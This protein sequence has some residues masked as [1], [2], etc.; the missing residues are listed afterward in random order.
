[1]RDLEE[2][3]ES[4]DLQECLALKEVL[5]NQE[6]LVNFLHQEHCHQGKSSLEVHQAGMKLQM[7]ES[8]Q[9]DLMTEL[10][11]VFHVEAFLLKAVLVGTAFDEVDIGH[12]QQASLFINR[13]MVKKLVFISNLQNIQHFKIIT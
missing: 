1:M 4:T 12:H 9:L 7:E 5:M 10:E 2:V 13:E 11:V 3:D 8:A 6:D